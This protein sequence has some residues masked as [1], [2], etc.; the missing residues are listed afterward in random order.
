MSK[1]NTEDEDDRKA[2]Q[3]DSLVELLEALDKFGSAWSNKD[4][5]EIGKRFAPILKETAAIWATHIPAPHL[6]CFYAAQLRHMITA[7][8]SALADKE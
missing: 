4:T 5:V 6:A 3:L 8:M 1:E 2:R 7:G